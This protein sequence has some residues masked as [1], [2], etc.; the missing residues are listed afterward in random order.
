MFREGIRYWVPVEL[1][2]RSNI[3]QLIS[4]TVEAAG[5]SESAIGSASIAIEGTNELRVLSPSVLFSIVRLHQ[6]LII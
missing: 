4:E 1:L 5:A 3:D 2:Q 6:S